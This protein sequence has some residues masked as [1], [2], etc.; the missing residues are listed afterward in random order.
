M[1]ALPLIAITMGDPAGVGPEVILKALSRPEP[2]ELCRPLVLGDPTIMERAS[3][4]L[5]GVMPIR[6]LNS[7]REPVNPKEV[8]L[9][10]ATREELGRTRWGKVDP[11]CGRAQVD[12]LR[13]AVELAMAGEVQAVV[14]APIHKVG[15]RL[16]GVPFPGHTEML[17]AWTG[18]QSF[19]MMLAGK[20]LRVVPVTLH[21][22]LKE[23]LERITTQGIKD[24][25]RLAHEALR[26]WFG[27]PAPRLAIAGLNPHAGDG[28]L[29]GDEEER[30]IS[31]AIKALQQEEIQVQGPMVP[32]AV[33]KMAADGLFDVVVAM[34]HDQGLIPLKLLERDQA[35]NLTLGLPIIRTSVD[36]GTAYDIAGTG[37][38]SEG[39]LLEAL[40]LA[41]RLAGS[42]VVPPPCHGAAGGSPHGPGACSE[43]DPQ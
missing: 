12:F 5:G 2:W 35:V 33:F 26:N 22:S 25:A 19:A 29:F 27:I 39:S 42:A 17:A 36:H 9:M 15:L 40:K 28:G 14:T 4:V 8:A 34:Y 6:V 38:A 11:R 43:P 3:R 30:I 21:C 31:P 24:A 18:A 32:D 23:A 37:K 41:A 20:S 16:A 13:K 10:R 1:R 7:V